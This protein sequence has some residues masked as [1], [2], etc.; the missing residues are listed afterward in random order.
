MCFGHSCKFCSKF[1]NLIS[2][3]IPILKVIEIFSLRISKDFVKLNIQTLMN[4][5]K[6]YLSSNLN[7]QNCSLHNRHNNDNR[8]IDPNDDGLDGVLLLFPQLSSRNFG[9]KLINIITL[10]LV[11]VCLLLSSYSA[12][13]CIWSP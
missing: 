7:L 4:F 3:S 10:D 9:M 6:P 13:H 11:F 12:F 5:L 1:I 8:S 2:N